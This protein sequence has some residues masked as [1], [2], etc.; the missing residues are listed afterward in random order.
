MTELP[1]PQISPLRE[2]MGRV[3]APEA[4]EVGLAAVASAFP[5][6]GAAM[7]EHEE[8][9]ARR[10]ADKM[11]AEAEEAHAKAIAMRGQ[12][13]RDA[14]TMVARA[15]KRRGDDP[16]NWTVADAD[17]AHVI[18]DLL[19]R[20]QGQEPTPLDPAF[21]ERDDNL[22]EVAALTSALDAAARTRLARSE[23][24]PSSASTPGPE[25]EPERAELPEPPEPPAAA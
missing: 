4:S 16:T 1:R 21:A 23:P 15:I 5:K 11:K 25:V 22:A 3:A 7:S 19:V 12:A 18:A 9:E 10:A 20:L 2:R 14:A 17:A 24:A 13:R 8:T 6:F